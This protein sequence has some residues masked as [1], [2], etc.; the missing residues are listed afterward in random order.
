[1]KICC[2]LNRKSGGAENIGTRNI[3]DLFATR[4][5]TVEILKPSE[6][7]LLRDLATQ[8]LQQNYDIVVAGG[9][10]GT[11]SAVASALVGH[12]TIRL[13]I[14]PLGTLNHFARDLGIPF[15]MPKAVEI[16]C[17]GYSEAKDVGAVNERYF[18]NNASVGIYPAIV[19]L[20]ESL[21]GTGYS[22]KW[23]VLISSFRALRSFRRFELD[24]QPSN[25]PPLKI[26]TAMLFV[27]NNAYG[28]VGT[29]MGKRLAIDLGLLW[30]TIPTASSR[31]G[32]FF[33]LLA[34][35]FGYEKPVNTLTLEVSSLRVSS[36]KRLLKVATDGEVS[37]L[38]PPLNFRIVPK[39]LNVIIPTP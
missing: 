12:P 5:F 10:D 18:V 24:I 30:V 3:V 20:R 11:I 31:T 35:V 7:N 29:S 27:G 37:L 26:K 39:A 36:K 16:I 13:G 25:G 21:Q 19:K 22:K 6:R 28:T 1:L 2:I 14:L 15:N 32:L 23:A 4:G 33:N 17:G 38:K 34:M 8:A 9:G